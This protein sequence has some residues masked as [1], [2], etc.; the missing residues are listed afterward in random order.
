MKYVATRVQYNG[1]QD[2]MS[3]KTLIYIMQ[4]CIRDDDK[5]HIVGFQQTELV[6][7]RCVIF[8]KPK[9]GNEC[10]VVF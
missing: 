5:R 8:L 3:L 2:L 1:V 4:F 6:R 9:K 10:C 7:S